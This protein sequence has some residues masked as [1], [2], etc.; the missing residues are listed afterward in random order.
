LPGLDAANGV[1]PIE[2]DEA[3][4]RRCLVAL[5]A[6]AGDTLAVAFLPA[7]SGA[8][9]SLAVGYFDGSVRIWDLGYFN[10]HLD[11][12]AE[13]QRALRSGAATRPVREPR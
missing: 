7:A 1:D 5:N 4:R 6:D 3:D 12:Q 2:Q 9:A 13:Y 10:R 11:G 8:G